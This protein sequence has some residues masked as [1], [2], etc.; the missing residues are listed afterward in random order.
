MSRAPRYPV[1]AETLVLGGAQHNVSFTRD[2]S[3]TGVFIET[4]GEFAPGAELNL[5][6]GDAR[7]SKVLRVSAEVVRAQPGVGFGARFVLHSAGSDDRVR[8]F[9]ERLATA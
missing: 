5:L 2:I 6:I 1:H 4:R 9:V 7:R 3:T 8:E